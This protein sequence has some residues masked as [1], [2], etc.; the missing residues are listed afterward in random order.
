MPTASEAAEQLLEKYEALGAAATS[1][2]PFGPGDGCFSIDEPDHRCEPGTRCRS[3]SGCLASIAET[4]GYD[5]T[6]DAIRSALREWL[7]TK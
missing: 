1:S 5:A 6:A 3:G 2:Y 4:V 7:A